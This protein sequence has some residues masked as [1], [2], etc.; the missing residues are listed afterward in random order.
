MKI[1][2]DLYKQIKSVNFY[3]HQFAG[4]PENRILFV[5]PVMTNFDW[6][7]MLIP[8]F[9]LEELGDVKTALTGLYR[10]SEIESK[11]MTEI[12]YQEIEWA[13]AIV[14][15]FSLEQYW[16]MNYLYHEIKM[17]KPEIKI[18]LT[19]EF[20]FYEIGKDHYLLKDNLEAKEMIIE[21]LHNNCLH[22]DRV[23]VTSELLGKKLMEKGI[24]DVKQVPMLCDFD[25][26]KENI[27]FQE[28]LGVKNTPDMFVCDLNEQNV[29]SFEAYLDV[30]I[31]LK[32]K[33]SDRFR[34]V[35][36]GDDPKK[37][38][39]EI[40]FE[41][42][43]LSKG[44]IVHKYKNIVKSVADCHLVLNKKNDYYKNSHDISD[45]IE[46][47]F[48][49]IPLIAMNT[50]PYKSVIKKNETGYLINSRKQLLDIVEK[51]MSNKEDLIKVSESVKN[52]VIEDYQIDKK[53]KTLIKFDFCF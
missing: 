22:A 27:D 13:D 49:S 36:I 50:D 42:S 11:P 20:D 29:D 46:R 45:F 33:Y 15:P 10:Y 8:Y 51:N 34:L 37:Y 35:V 53:T 19:V 18:C 48:F 32:D 17:V 6:Y 4:D 43:Y 2:S 38:F 40:D 14:L 44:S 5:D 28:T 9:A 30:F 1:V 21:R 47:G 26:I 24:K 16:G 3:R 23:L 12:T 41:Y 52:Q 25:T 7:T 39:K 31:E